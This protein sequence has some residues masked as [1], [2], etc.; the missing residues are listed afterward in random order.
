MAKDSRLPS[1]ECPSPSTI[2]STTYSNLRPM[3]RARW[4]WADCGF[5]RIWTEISTASLLHSSRWRLKLSLLGFR[6]KHPQQNEEMQ[7]WI[8]LSRPAGN[9]L[10]KQLREKTIEAP[11]AKR[12][13]IPT[14][15]GLLR[16]G[17]FIPDSSHARARP[18]QHRRAKRLCRGRSRA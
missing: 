14:R 1:I 4:M 12:E 2:T 10:S 11:H 5:S 16:P 15:S 8:E 17:H 13:S 6:R 9:A 18:V 3:Q 7:D